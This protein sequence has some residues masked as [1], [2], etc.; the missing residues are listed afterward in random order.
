MSYQVKVDQSATAELDEVMDWYEGQKTGLGVDFLLK[1][2]NAVTFLK[3]NPRLYPEVYQ[4]FR[5]VLMKKYP[6]AIYYAIAEANKEVVV[7]AVWQ[8]SQAPDKLRKRLR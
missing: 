4:S 7:L 1:F 5:R 3:E 2:Y 6:Y 8:T